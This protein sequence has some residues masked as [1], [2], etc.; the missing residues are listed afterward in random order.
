M[1]DR[2]NVALWQHEA[3]MCVRFRKHASAC[4]G[5]AVIIVDGNK[6][7]VSLSLLS[8]TLVGEG[9]CGWKVRWPWRSCCRAQLVFGYMKGCCVCVCVCVRKMKKF[10]LTLIMRLSVNRKSWHWNLI[11]SRT[12]RVLDLIQ[13]CN[14]FRAGCSVPRTPAEWT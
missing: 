9:L 7:N 1:S 12:W 5:A 3:S 6:S 11:L 14:L 4:C 10:N 8:Y 13:Q 2:L